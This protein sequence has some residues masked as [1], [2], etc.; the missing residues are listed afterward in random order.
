LKGLQLAWLERKGETCTDGSSAWVFQAPGQT[1]VVIKLQ[2][3]TR[4][5]QQGS[6]WQ[7]WEQD[8]EELSLFP[9]YQALVS[10]FC[11][12]SRLEGRQLTLKQTAFLALLTLLSVCSSCDQVWPERIQSKSTAAASYPKRS[13]HSWRIQNQTTDRLCQSDR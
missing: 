3:R 8:S 5:G 1:A 13:H 7:N 2:F 11:R 6:L 12:L 9:V 4:V 10:T